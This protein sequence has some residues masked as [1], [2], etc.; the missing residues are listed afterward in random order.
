MRSPREHLIPLN[1][2]K[3]LIIPHLRKDFGIF[4]R[5]FSVYPHRYQ[6]L[7]SKEAARANG[8]GNISEPQGCLQDGMQSQQMITMR[9]STRL[10]ES[11]YQESR[12][13]VSPLDDG[14]SA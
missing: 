10:T 6:L 12:R 13:I 1:D 14:G 4:H 3:L 11:A 8:Q 5:Y 9:P 2:A 7:L